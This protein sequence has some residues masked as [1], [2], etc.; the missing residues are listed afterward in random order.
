MKKKWLNV[1]LATACLSMVAGFVGCNKTDKDT[2]STVYTLNKEETAYILTEY[3]GTDVNYT[4]P[5]TYKGLPVVEI[6]N[7]AF[8]DCDSLEKLVIPS[9]IKK[10]GNGV[11]GSCSNLERVDIQ[12]GVEELGSG[13]FFDCD[14]LTSINV[15]ENNENYQSIDGD[16]YSKD[17]KTLMQYAVGKENA[18]L[19]VAETV[20]KI[21]DF[22]FGGSDYLTEVV[23]PD[24]VKTL[25]STFYQCTELKKVTLGQNLT[26]IDRLTFYNC[27][28]L[29]DIEIPATV[30]YI[31]NRAFTSCLSL[32]EIVLPEKLKTID[33]SAFRMCSSLTTVKTNN[34]LQ[35][36]GKEAFSKCEQL[37]DFV[38]P[39]SVKTLDQGAFNDCLNVTFYCGAERVL[40]ENG[41]V[42]LPSGWNLTFY[43]VKTDVEGN[44]S[45]N[46]PVYWYSENEPALNA[47]GTAYNGNFWRYVD[48]TVTPW[49]YAP[50]AA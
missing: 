18:T 45:V 41:G 33:E 32:T 22:A 30:T 15:A 40:D 17:G 39:S 26:R 34:G 20:T 49:V 31:G 25:K 23:L 7:S 48:D 35:V 21:E 46:R 10:V 12:E 29:T 37:A 13:L 4:I 14:K 43:R 2:K 8:F 5:A 11:F 3:H 1:L 9:T 24:T 19:T 27:E 6:A 36:I 28:N 38:I 42:K 44:N 50:V 47:E 16:L